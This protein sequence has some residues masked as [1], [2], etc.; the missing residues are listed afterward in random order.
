MKIH[1]KWA[2]ANIT[3][4]ETVILNNNIL[5]GI[6]QINSFSNSFFVFNNSNFFFSIEYPRY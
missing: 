5:I 2:E 4:F 1:P 3:W 6:I